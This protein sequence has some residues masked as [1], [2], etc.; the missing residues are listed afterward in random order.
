M[1]VCECGDMKNGYFNVSFTDEDG[2]VSEIKQA[3]NRIDYSELYGQ[4]VISISD[5]AGV[6]LKTIAVSAQEKPVDPVI[7]DQPEKPTEP[8]DPVDPENLPNRISP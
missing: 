1:R 6:A 2:V 7:P 8:T 4:V 3:G 5:E